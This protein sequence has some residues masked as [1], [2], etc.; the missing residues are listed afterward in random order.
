MSRAVENLMEAMNRAMKNRPLVGGFPYLAETLR[1]AGATRNLWSLPSCQSIYLTRWGAVV[2]QGVPLMN[3]FSEVP[4]FNQELLI[5]ALRTDQVGK[6]TF[7]EF[8]S[9]VWKAGITSYDVD[10]EKRH[11]IYYGSL[12]ESYLEEYPVVQV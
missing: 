9:A 11:V 10:F 6:S 2:N 5:H 1:S 12:G 8:L 3:G 7:P 4:T